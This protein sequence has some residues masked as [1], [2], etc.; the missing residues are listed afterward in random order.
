MHITK[1]IY[2]ST[3]KFFNGGG[4]KMQINKS[5]EAEAMTVEIV[6]AINYEGAKELKQFFDSVYDEVIQMTIDM[7]QAD[8]VSSAGMRV[9]L[10]AELAM[11]NKAGLILINVNQMVMEAMHIAG[12]DKFLNI[13]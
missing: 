4:V 12:F 9:I 7:S 3:Q 8:Y 1:E 6:G 5:V 11:K 13:K 2:T 10:E